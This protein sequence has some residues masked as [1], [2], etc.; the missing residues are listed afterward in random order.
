MKKI[1]PSDAI[2][3]PDNAELK[4]QGVIFRVYNWPQQVFNGSEETFEMLKRTDTVVAL[5]I[6]ED[7]LLLLEDEQP[8]KGLKLKL[9][10]GQVDP[11][12]DSTLAAVKREVKEETGYDFNSWK[13]IKVTQPHNEMEWF[14]YLYLA[15]DPG[16][17]TEL[18]L[19]AGEKIRVR[20]V[21]LEEYKNLV[22]FKKNIL[23]ENY[24]TI[25][26]INSLDELKNM[27]EYTGQEVER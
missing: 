21:S 22:D 6:V 26:K 15:W 18:N 4:Y 2:L 20:Q 25:S 14:V 12:D 19:D 11:K 3:I 23:T 13:L 5:A 8:H 17:K 16:E 10:G 1:V 27:S 7:K 24:D 9:P